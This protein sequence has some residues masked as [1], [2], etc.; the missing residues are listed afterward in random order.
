MKLVCIHL[1]LNYEETALR[2]EFEKKIE[3]LFGPLMKEY[4][5]LKTLIEK[6]KQ[7]QESHKIS[8]EAFA[9]KI[10]RVPEPCL[11]TDTP[12]AEVS[13]SDA[14]DNLTKSLQQ[15]VALSENITHWLYS[16]AQTLGHKLLNLL[17]CTNV[18]PVEALKCFVNDVNDLKDTIEAY[19]PIVEKY[20]NEVVALAKEL[21]VEFKECLGFSSK[22]QAI[23]SKM[24]LK[25]QLCE[26]YLA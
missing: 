1:G 15:A 23:A 22:V 26:N 8:S 12:V 16:A 19:K 2:D 11:A 18:N 5:E 3:E 6:I 4:N 20:K 21:K 14:C 13:D 24:L 25:A 7:Y 17:H 10:S 9:E